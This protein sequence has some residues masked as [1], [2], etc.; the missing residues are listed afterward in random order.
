MCDFLIVFGIRL[1][2]LT[3]TVLFFRFAKQIIQY[4]DFSMYQN[5][6]S[7]SYRKPQRKQGLEGGLHS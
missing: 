5:D 2:F 6:L 4:L 1:I 7:R 3:L